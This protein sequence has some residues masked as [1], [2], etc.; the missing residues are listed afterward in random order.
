[1]LLLLPPTIRS[2]SVTPL[3]LP[4]PPRL[5]P[6][7]LPL[8]IFLP[9]SLLLPPCLRCTEVIWH[10]H[11]QL[12]CLQL[13]CSQLSDVSAVRHSI[14]ASLCSQS[15]RLWLAPSRLLPVKPP[16]IY[17][18]VKVTVFPPEVCVLGPSGPPGSPGPLVP[19]LVS[20]YGRTPFN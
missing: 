14:K 5:P 1:M 11:I 13:I 17:S 16:S 7:S 8:F 12:Y 2:F 18:E 6:L 9:L 4:P 19:G 10:G 20:G 15:S 3:Y